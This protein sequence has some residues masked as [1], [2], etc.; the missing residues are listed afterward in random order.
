M[1]DE[2]LNHVRHITKSDIV[3]VLKIVGNELAYMR[4][5]KG[6]SGAELGKL[7]GMSQQ[8]ISRYEN[9]V[10]RLDLSTLLSFLLRLDTTLDDFFRHISERLKMY[11]PMLYIKYHFIFSSGITSREISPDDYLKAASTLTM[12]SYS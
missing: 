12:E 6:I 2:K 10:T 3:T 9:G 1:H 7:L 5:N 8:Q 11:H 4:K